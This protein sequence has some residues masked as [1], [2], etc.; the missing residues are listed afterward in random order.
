MRPRKKEGKLKKKKITI[1]CRVCLM[2]DTYTV[3]EKHCRYCGSKLFKI[4][5]V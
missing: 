4:D 5:Q 2:V 1:R 3:D